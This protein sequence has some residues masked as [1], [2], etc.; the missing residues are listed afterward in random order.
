MP[1]TSDDPT[2]GEWIRQERELNGLTLQDAVEHLQE[3]TP[4]SSNIRWS[5]SGLCEIERGETMPKL[6]RI[7]IL[8]EY[9]KLSEDK[10]RVAFDLAREQRRAQKGKSYLHHDLN[11]DIR[12]LD[13]ARQF[14]NEG[15]AKVALLIVRTVRTNC[16]ERRKKASSDYLPILT[17]LEVWTLVEEADICTHLYDRQKALSDLQ[18]IV[19]DIRQLEKQPHTQLPL[20]LRVYLESFIS[21]SKYQYENALMKIRSI[22]FPE[23]SYGQYNAPLWNVQYWRTYGISAVHAGSVRD[24]RL[25]IRKLQKALEGD[26]VP[27]VRSKA[28]ES[29][30]RMFAFKKS[31][32]AIYWFEQSQK[33]LPEYGESIR[34]S[35]ARTEF[36]LMYYLGM[37]SQVSL[38]KLIERY[39]SIGVDCKW[40]DEETMKYQ[41]RLRRKY[42]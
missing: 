6:T 32:E 26:L 42:H 25:A 15:Q 3:M 33:A 21:Y 5:I 8:A 13:L 27:R 7:Q 34:K 38:D 18:G 31:D 35:N 20:H 2:G 11:E 23:Q 12:F 41:Q 17:D 14:V 9:Y 19:N 40:F 16:Q 24:Q 22:P 1:Y 28:A 29:I 4:P 30:A 10:L 37:N 39:R 36:E